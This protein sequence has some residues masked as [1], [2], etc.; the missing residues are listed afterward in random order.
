[1]IMV[2]LVLGSCGKY[3]PPALPEGEPNCYPT[4]Y[5]P[6]EQGSQTCP[7]KCKKCL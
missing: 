1:M 7:K 2:G 5:P 3:G 6:E 4:P